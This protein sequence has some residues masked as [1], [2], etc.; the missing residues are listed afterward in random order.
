MINKMKYSQG[1]PGVSRSFTSEGQRLQAK[2]RY[3]VDL[4]AF[5]AECETNYLRF[6][7]L[8]PLLEEAGR[9]LQIALSPCKSGHVRL[10]VLETTPFTTLLGVQWD[11]ADKPTW[12]RAPAMRARIYHDAQ[13][14]EV[15]ACDRV[16]TIPPRHSYPNARMFQP[17]EK[18]QWNRFFGE[19]L[20]A[21]LSRGYRMAKQLEPGGGTAPAADLLPGGV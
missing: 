6:C 20:A 12:L 11:G 8:L 4:K 21:C 16:C 2:W 10:S 5:M 9:E 18:A 19:L 3:R 13:L 7:K 15:V 14:A 17:D 1:S